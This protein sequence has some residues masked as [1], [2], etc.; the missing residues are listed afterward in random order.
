MS[1][2]SAVIITQDEEKNISGC[3]ESVAWADEIIIID[4]GSTDRTI[5]IAKN[6]GA[7]VFETEWRGF[8]YSKRLGVEKAGSEWI[9]SIDADEQVT[10]E[11]SEEIKKAIMENATDGYYIPRLTNFL[12]KWI[13]H[14]GWYPD[15][16]LRLFKKKSGNFSDA[17]VHE[18]A[19]IDGKIGR[20]KYNL[21]HYSYP[22]ID[23]YFLKLKRYSTLAAEELHKRG[24][25][26]SLVALLLKPAAAFYR[27]YIFRAGFMDGIEG[28]LIAVLSAFGVMIRYIKLRRLEK[29][30]RQ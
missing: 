5:D 16:V 4:S 30:S 2:V 8:G 15:Y 6:A 11:L 25:K 14:S 7:K 18:K 29:E 10:L 1:S 28:Y 24:K 12:G 21:L 13:R 23:T 26:Y 20:M 9:L 22:D 19:M 27:H 3:L 17:L